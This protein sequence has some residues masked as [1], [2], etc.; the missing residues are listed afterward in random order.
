MP[1]GA[2]PRESVQSAVHYPADILFRHFDIGVTIGRRA[3][4][5][6]SVAFCCKML[7]STTLPTVNNSIH[8]L[9]TT[10]SIQLLYDPMRSYA[11][12]MHSF[13]FLCASYGLPMECL[14]RVI[15]VLPEKCAVFRENAGERAHR[16][17]VGK[18]K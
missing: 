7:H 3:T 16:E 17:K 14:C 11:L 1:C 18:N 12:S 4:T 15:T 2:Y 10:N 6:K 9:E 13:G 8:C 5:R